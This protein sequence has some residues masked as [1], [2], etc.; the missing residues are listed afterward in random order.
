MASVPLRVCRLGPVRGEDHPCAWADTAIG[1]VQLD[2]NRKSGKFEDIL[3]PCRPSLTQD[4]P[5]GRETLSG[6]ARCPCRAHGR[7][8]RTPFRIP[9]SQQLP[10]D[11]T[12]CSASLSAPGGCGNTGTYPVHI[13][14]SQRRSQN[15][16]GNGPDSV[17][18]LPKPSM[19]PDFGV[20]STTL[21]SALS[22]P[23]FTDVLRRV[24]V[25]FPGRRPV[26]DPGPAWSPVP[27]PPMPAW[28]R[29]G[30]HGWV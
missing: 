12:R 27:L 22:G 11:A 13:G 17:S 25:P 15:L 24:A 4:G 6:F 21:P 19:G 1:Q 9:Q 2:V 14:F 28:P 10:G 30:R 3:M 26:P 18:S 16:P 5:N 23:T 8:N 20:R 29:I 7:E